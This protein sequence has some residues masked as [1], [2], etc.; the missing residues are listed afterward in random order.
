M[1][2]KS[3]ILNKKIPGRKIPWNSHTDISKPSTK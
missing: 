1:E 3:N 2:N